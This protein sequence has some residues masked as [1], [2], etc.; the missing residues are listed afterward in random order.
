M[1]T[2][3]QDACHDLQNRNHVHMFLV[4]LLPGLFSDISPSLE[5]I[6][7]FAFCIILSQS[8]YP[9]AFQ[10]VCY[11]MSMYVWYIAPVLDDARSKLSQAARIPTWC[12]WNLVPRRVVASAN[13]APSDNVFLFCQIC[14]AFT[15]DIFC[16]HFLGNICIRRLTHLIPMT[17]PVTLRR[18][19][20]D[21]LVNNWW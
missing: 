3:S 7:P 19:H 9:R 11:V 14:S 6:G 1:G 4:F 12:S 20:T 18:V 10:T 5:R 16:W 8:V 21:I 2:Q 17:F 13:V 15:F